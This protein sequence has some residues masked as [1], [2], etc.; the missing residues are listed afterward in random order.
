MANYIL[1]LVCVFASQVIGGLNTKLPPPSYGNTITILSID[2]GG[3]KGIIPSVVLARLEKILQVVSN[4]EKAAVADYFDVI[5]GTSTGGLIAAMLAAPNSND[6]SRP[7][8]TAAEILKF[9]LDFGPSI[10]NQTSAIGWNQ[11]SPRPKYDG[12]FLHDKAREILQESRLHD[13]LTNLVIP[14]FDI[15]KVHPVIFSNFKVDEVPS[16]DAKLSDISIG[17]SA[18]PTLLPPYH[19]ENDGAEFNLID[20]GVAAGNPALVALSEVA[21]QLN[22]KNPDFIR[23]NSNEPLKIVLLSLGCGRLVPPGVEARYAYFLSAVQW[24][25]LGVLGLATAAADLN[26]YHLASVF[27]DIPSSENY[28]LRVEEY[29]L[30][31][32]IG[33][34]DTSKESLEKL[35]KAGEDLL[36]Q[37]VKTL[38]VTSFV[39]H[40]KPSEGTNDEALKSQVIGGLNTKLPPP[41]Y[42]NTITILSI[43]GG[44]IKGIIPSVVLARLEKILQVVSNDEKAAVADYFDVIA[45]TSTGGLIAAMLAA[46][47]SDDPSRPASTA[48]E[49]L[50]FY[51]DFGPSIFNQTSAIGWN[52]TSP[53]PKYGG[54][55]LH[56]KAREILQESRLH[57]TL[58]NLVIPAF[59]ILKV[60][61]VIF[62]NFKVDEV[63]SLDAKLSD[64]SIGTSAAPTLLPP[65]HF[66]NDGAEFNLIDG[67]V[68]A[69]NPAL[70][71][72]SEVAQQLNAKNPDFVRVN[73]NQ[74]LKIVL[75]SL[76]CGRLVP[77]GVE[78]RYAYFLSAVQ[79][80]PLGVLGLATAA[81]DINEYHLASVFPDIP[82][83]EN[84]YLRVE[85]YNLDPS[86]GFDDTSKESLEKLVK[87]GEDLLVQTVKTLNVTSFVPHEKPSEGT[88]D[89]ALKRLA[90]FLYIEKVLRLKKKSMEKRGRPFVE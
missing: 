53:R 86:I 47:N 56:D 43:D 30:D 35:V 4:D 59:D 41:S 18:A 51:L 28:Y 34:D 74:P 14:A 12:K 31:P 37:T 3:I 10:F 66:E 70:V 2:G 68:A 67:G 7:A 61:P 13:T 27:P 90:E 20:G 57:D 11:T 79:W 26:E 49:I 63:P 64:I 32:S 39:P 54:K 33:F 19:F 40:E 82:S 36:L 87:A 15:L 17:T 44:G 73:S 65:Y 6:P 46:P 48:A 50:K 60:H 85:E 72:L 42:G 16:L 62:S 89:E 88:N 5:A 78:A 23:V 84:Y 9:Y 71:A 58:T 69:G 55:F 81:A 24:I 80:I 8:S 76:G 45:G 29:N 1:F 77:P 52:Q 75:L 25:P 38:D 83:S 21:Q 22:A